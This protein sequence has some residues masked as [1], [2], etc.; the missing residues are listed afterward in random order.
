MSIY[1]TVGNDDP[2]QQGEIL[3]E[4]HLLTWEQAQ[5]RALSWEAAESSE[6]VIILTQA[7]D[8]ANAKT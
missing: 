5:S 8:L 4:C 2:L 1:R 7:C 6:R 3:D